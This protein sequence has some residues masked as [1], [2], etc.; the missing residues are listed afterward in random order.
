MKKQRNKLS[1]VARKPSLFTKVVDDGEG[2][3]LSEGEQV[4]GLAYDDDEDDEYGSAV[5]ITKQ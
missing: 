5:R 3:L 2:V 4:P 1:F